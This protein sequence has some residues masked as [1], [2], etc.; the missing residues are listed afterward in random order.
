MIVHYVA[1]AQQPDIQLFCS[2]AWTTPAWGPPGTHQPPVFKADNGEH[3]T[4][5]RGHVTCEACVKKLW[6][7]AKRPDVCG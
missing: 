5:T 1:W 2:Q 6:E 7:A 3:Y 4:F